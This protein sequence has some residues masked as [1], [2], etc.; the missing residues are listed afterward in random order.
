MRSVSFSQATKDV[1]LARACGGDLAAAIEQ[2]SRE[3]RVDHVWI[4]MDCGIPERILV[5]VNTRSLR[6]AA[7]GFD[8][9][10]RVGITRGRTE[11]LPPRGISP[12]ARFDYTE[13]ESGANFFYEHKTRHEAEALLIGLCEES[14][15][16]EAWGA[17]Y[18]RKRRPGL[19]QIHSRRASCV[20]SEDI[21]GRDGG[22][23]FYR[24][25]DGSFLWTM[26]FI[27]FC[28]QL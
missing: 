2:A 27:K 10:V 14:E 3:E 8:P 11:C 9:R 15:L 13:S 16:L 4:A 20:V 17:P 1:P 5:S 22:L 19:H 23:K 25:D 21:Q 7:A 24:R 26:I 18:S 12:L 28:G 6:N